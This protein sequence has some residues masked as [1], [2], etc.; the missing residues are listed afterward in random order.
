M[1]V[2]TVYVTEITNGYRS[3]RAR[4]PTEEASIEKA[5]RDWEKSMLPK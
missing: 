2:E 4:G 3:V 5:K 1:G